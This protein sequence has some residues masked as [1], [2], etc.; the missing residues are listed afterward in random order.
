MK[1]KGKERRMGK[2]KM[3]ERKREEKEGREKE[4]REKEGRE[5]EGREKEGREKEGREKEGR[6]KEGRERKEKIREEGTRNRMPK[7]VMF[8]VFFFIFSHYPF[9]LS[10]LSLEGE[11]RDS[12]GRSERRPRGEKNDFL[13]LQWMNP[14]K[15]K[16]KIGERNQ[17]NEE[18]ERR[19]KK[20]DKE[21]KT[22]QN[23]GL[24]FIPPEQQVKSR[25]M[26]P[27]NTVCIPFPFLLYFCDSN[28]NSLYLLLFYIY[29]FLNS[30][31]LDLVVCS[32]WD[33]RAR[34]NVREVQIE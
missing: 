29:I 25:E 27:S 22:Y 1:I 30:M 32:G 17:G 10:F 4:G 3:G 34:A 11:V 26:D 5:K 18:K 6:E 15:R 24:V 33:E 28:F 7:W 21:K 20:S 9:T 16:R 23:V 2:R 31:L 12:W 13:N 8:L 14:K 19:E